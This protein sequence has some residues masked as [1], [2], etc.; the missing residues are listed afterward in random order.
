MDQN[1]V[2]SVNEFQ[3]TQAVLIVRPKYV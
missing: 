1:S 2:K 3:T